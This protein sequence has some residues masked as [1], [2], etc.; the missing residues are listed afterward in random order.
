V[1][2]GA[3]APAAGHTQT[4]ARPAGAPEVAVGAE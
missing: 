1:R 4:A 2:G 3:T